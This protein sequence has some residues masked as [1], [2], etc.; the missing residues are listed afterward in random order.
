MGNTALLPPWNDLNPRYVAYC[1][2][3][4][5]SSPDEMRERDRLAWPG[6]RM[7]GFILWMNAQWIDWGNV[8]PSRGFKGVRSDFRSEEHLQDFDRFLW[9][10][11]EPRPHG[12]R[13]ALAEMESA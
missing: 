9:E 12:G 13:A 6:G 1:L 2:A 11:V 8:A 7:C 4:G 5:A 10:R 3:H